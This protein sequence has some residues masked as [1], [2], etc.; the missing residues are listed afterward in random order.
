MSTEDEDRQWRIATGNA[1]E[2]DHWRE[3]DNRRWR[4][5]ERFSAPGVQVMIQAAR[6]TRRMARAHS[7]VRLFRPPLALRPRCPVCGARGYKAIRRIGDQIIH[8]CRKGHPH[9]ALN[10]DATV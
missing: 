1:S 10:E 2:D 3:E 9:Y 4:D 7:A 8:W 6:G 5:R